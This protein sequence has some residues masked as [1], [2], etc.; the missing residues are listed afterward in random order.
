MCECVGRVCVCRCMGVLSGACVGIHMCMRVV[1]WMLN[2]WHTTELCAT[3]S[4]YIF[5]LCRNL[6]IN[7]ITEIPTDV[8]QPLFSIKSLLVCT[9]FMHGVFSIISIAPYIIIHCP[10][11]CLLLYIFT[12]HRSVAANVITH[13]PAN[14]FVN[15]SR[16]RIM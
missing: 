13:L 15:N 1:R 8:F 16:L 11:H 12:L 2:A 5:Y 3:Y 6:D 7:L 10:M 14:L 4:W 9:G